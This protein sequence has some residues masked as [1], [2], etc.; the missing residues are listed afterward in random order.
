MKAKKLLAGLLSAAMVL[1]AMVLPAFADGTCVAKIGNVEYTDL[2]SAL[3]AACKNDTV[4]LQGD[5]TLTGD[6]TPI[7]K[8]FEGTLDGNGKT[9]SGL[10]ITKPGSYTYKNNNDENITVSGA[11]LFVALGGTVKNLTIAGADVSVNENGYAG[12]LAGHAVGA[13]TNNV[14]I[15]GAN[16][17]AGNT[18]KNLQY[19]G[20]LFGHGYGN[21][22]SCTVSNSNIT[23]DDQVG[24][25][26]GFLFCG[27]MTNCQSISNTI[28]ANSER[29]GGLLGKVSAAKNDLGP[30]KLIVT[31]CTVSGG[32][33]TA[34]DFAGGLFGQFMGDCAMYEINGNTVNNINLSANKTEYLYTIREEQN[35]TFMNALSTNVNG[36][37]VNG[38]ID[39]NAGNAQDV[40]DGRYGDI[41]GKTIKFTESIGTVLDLAG[42]TKYKGGGT[43]YYKGSDSAGTKVEWSESLNTETLGTGVCAYY[44]TLKDV[45]FT[46]NDGVETAGFTFGAGHC[47]GKTDAAITDPVRGTNIYDT[48]GSYYR[49][50]S[51]ENITFKGLTFTG[52]FTAVFSLADCTVKDITFD[53][54]TFKG[55]TQNMSNNG[56]AAIHTQTD[57]GKCENITVKD[58]VITNYYQGIYTQ[59]CS[60]TTTIMGNYISNTTHNGLAL[61]SGTNSPVRGTVAVTDN[62]ISDT[63]DRA[64]KFGNIADIADIKINNNV[65]ISGTDTE[66]EVIKPGTIGE[67]CTIDLNNNYWSGQDASKAVA[68]GLPVPSKT[69][70]TSGTW[71]KEITDAYVANGYMARAN[72]DDG[73]WSVEEAAAEVIETDTVS[74]ITVTLNDL[75]AQENINL[76]EKATYEVVVTDN[77]DS[78]EQRTAEKAIKDAA[79]ITDDTESTTKLKVMDIS[80][81]ETK[82]G[83]GTEGKATKLEGD[84]GIKNQKV[85]VTLDETPKAATVKVYHYTN[86]NAKEITDVS[87]SGNTVTFTAPSFS[88]FGMSY[89]KEPAAKI[90]TAEYDT[91]QAAINAADTG[92]TITLNIDTA[93]SVVIGADKDITLDLNGKTLT[94]AN[95]KHTITNNGKLTVSDSSESK[96][97]AVDN[98]S[99]GKG[100]LVNAEGAE[101]VLNGGK[102]MRSAETGIDQDTSGGNSWYT[103]QNLGNMTINEGVTVENSGKFSSMITNGYYD[104]KKVEKPTAASLTINGGSLTG[105]LWAVKNDDMAVMKINGGMLESHGSGVIMNNN[106][107]EINGGTFVTDNTLP[108][109]YNQYIEGG[110]NAGT[111]K[112]TDGNFTGKF[113][114]VRTGGEIA[115]SGG[116]FSTDVSE[117]CADGFEAKKGADGRYAIDEILWKMYTD[118]G[119]YTADDTTYGMMRFMFAYIGDVTDKTVSG[120]GIKYINASEINDDVSK[121]SAVT[122]T[123]G[124]TA[125]QGD[126]VNITSDVSSETNYYARAFI[127]FDDST[128]VW[129]DPLKCNINR[130]RKFTD[131]KPQ[132]SKNNG[133]AE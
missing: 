20:G 97:G 13:E 86:S 107:I 35:E 1:S 98:I 108:A 68:G 93:E 60:G 14:N 28:E 109:L 39:V 132:A 102:F 58:C 36:N 113:V 123:G 6:W 125:F 105:G 81:Y 11:G 2:A 3:N 31:G 24:G 100:A 52:K 104:V 122:G 106:D 4:V 16:V 43:E 87:V 64:I 117:Y 26:V 92:D 96:S 50:S 119:C 70:I 37:A 124:A 59:G 75:H 21:L 110:Y 44:R 56:F 112:I 23:G 46:A 88:F 22:E 12:V 34:P 15:T 32:S 131:Y 80:V 57:N 67:N 47:Y 111:A 7:A 17:S 91:L 77:A 27:T 78:D 126:V 10:K 38:V 130:N 48:N 73:T 115:I 42:P 25:F 127:T 61:Q 62:Y 5:I 121:D 41:T 51:M 133:G 71:T 53:S 30:G 94:N 128:I 66:G 45:T 29:A 18:D 114:N 63:G 49:H 103:I 85:T 79:D 120:Y 95:D 72:D 54:C 89:Q 74:G 40:L 8:N 65:I 99:H 116:T 76:S 83:D 90:G 82:T 19:A 69:G 55:D 33:A 84:S 101:A 118:S 129:S 9:I